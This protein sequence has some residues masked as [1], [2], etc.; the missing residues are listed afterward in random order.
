M[1]KHPYVKF[2]LIGLTAWQYEIFGCFV[3][4]MMA[5]LGY[6]VYFFVPSKHPWL[7]LITSTAL[8]IIGI[9][10]PINVYYKEKFGYYDNEYNY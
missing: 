3:F 1:S 2:G 8:L 5:A 4:Y 10:S 6:C 7:M 9:L